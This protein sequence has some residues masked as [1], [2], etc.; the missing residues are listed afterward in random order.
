MSALR[1]RAVIAGKLSMSVG[2][3]AACCPK[4]GDTLIASVV[5]VLLVAG[6]IMNFVGPRQITEGV[7]NFIAHNFQRQA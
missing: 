1:E 2:H 3:P 6:W 5:L 7:G 4:R